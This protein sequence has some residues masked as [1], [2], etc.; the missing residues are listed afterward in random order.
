MA[1]AFAD[2]F[3]DVVLAVA[4]IFHQRPI[5]FRLFERIEVGALHVLDDRELQRFLVSRL[6]DDDRHFVQAGTL[7]RAPAPLAGDD[8]EGVRRAAN[9]PRHDRLND[10]ALAQRSGNSS[11]SASEKMRRGLRAFGRSELG[12]LR[13]A[14][15]ADARPS[16]RRRRRRSG[17]QVRGPIAIA[18]RPPPSPPSLKCHSQALFRV[19]SCTL[20]GRRRQCDRRELS[21]DSSFSRWMI[22]VASRR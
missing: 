5:A 17:R 12:R 3:G 1:A 19:Y 22:S 7:R 4:E 9:R 21:D 16:S 11:S 13:A 15:R 6:D 10:A 20:L 2:H 8:L 18:L 14:G